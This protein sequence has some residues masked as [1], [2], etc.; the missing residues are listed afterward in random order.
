MLPPTVRRV[1][2]T[3]AR[4]ITMRKVIVFNNV[5]LDGYIADAAGDMSWAQSPDPEWTAFIKGNADGRST[6]VFGRVTYDLM[7]S[8]WPT[9]AARQFDARLAGYMNSQPKLVFSRS[10]TRADWENTTLTADDPVET[11][12]RL[13]AEDGADMVIFGSGSIVAPL[14]ASGLIDTYMIATIPVA[15]GA[16]RTMFEGLA[17]PVRLSLANSRVFPNGNILA[18]YVPA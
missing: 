6:L 14:A 18:T 15:V 11:V 17:S 4:E 16:G 7:A 3:A 13:K 9:E 2:E 5:T 10:L 12:R 8:F 1:D